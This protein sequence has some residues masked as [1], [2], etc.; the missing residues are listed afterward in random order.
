[1]ST[2][3][4]PPSEG[5]SLF[6]LPEGLTPGSIDTIP[7]LSSLLSRIQNPSTTA[8]ST[9]GSPPAV[10]P[11][12]L[13]SGTGPLH[14]K[15]IPTATD[16]MKHKLQRAR[17]QVKELPDIDRSIEEQEEEIQELEEKIQKQKEVLNALRDVGSA[18]KL[19]RERKGGEDMMEL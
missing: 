17:V 15:D 2:T 18:T 11:A 10:S 7:I 6:N 8:A 13:A 4:Q 5:P 19:E 16:E 9:S 1:M 14:V 12:Q 3:P